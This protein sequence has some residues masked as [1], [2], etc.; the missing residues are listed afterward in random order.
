MSDGA[1]PAT[2]LLYVMQQRTNPIRLDYS[3]QKLRKSSRVLMAC[4]ALIVTAWLL[5]FVG[6]QRVSSLNWTGYDPDPDISQSLANDARRARTYLPFGVLAV[7]MDAG[8]CIAAIETCVQPQN[9][10]FGVSLLL[11][12]VASL[13]WHG[14]LGLGALFFAQ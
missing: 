12:S 14:F 5:V 1:G 13:A 11:V 8:A 6:R 7:L 3:H 4:C 2:E 9:R 10:W